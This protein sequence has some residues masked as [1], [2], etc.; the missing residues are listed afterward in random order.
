MSIDMHFIFDEY[1]S[2]ITFIN[3]IYEPH[4]PLQRVVGYICPIKCMVGDGWLHHPHYF[5]IDIYIPPFNTI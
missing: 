3:N 5:H 2:E 1:P 4:L